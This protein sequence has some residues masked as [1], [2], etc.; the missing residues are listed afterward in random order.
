ML[1]RVFLQ[2]CVEN[3]TNACYAICS[4]KNNSSD[5]CQPQ[6]TYLESYVYGK[7]SVEEQG[8]TKKN[9]YD[10]CSTKHDEK[11]FLN[12]LTDDNKSL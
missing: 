7:I 12:C 2:S 6:T 11:S 4:N 9:I 10:I 1:E 3:I 5:F 8:G